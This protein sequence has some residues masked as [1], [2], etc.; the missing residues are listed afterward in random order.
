[1]EQNSPK[2]MQNNLYIK[3]YQ[4]GYFK[5]MNI[6]IGNFFAFEDIYF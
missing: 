6:G 4:Q 2:S 5:I 1:M 3:R